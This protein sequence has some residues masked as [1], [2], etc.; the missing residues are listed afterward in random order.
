M[1]IKQA[2]CYWRVGS[3]PWSGDST[4]SNLWKDSDETMETS[5]AFFHQSKGYQYPLMRC[6][7]KVQDMYRK[8]EKTIAKISGADKNWI[9][10]WLIKGWRHHEGKQALVTYFWSS[11]KWTA[12]GCFT[13][14]KHGKKPGLQQLC[15]V[16]FYM[17]KDLLININRT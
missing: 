3:G 9:L 8:Q 10:P 15:E 1:K 7:L 14:L 17:E 4:K 5:R 6:S 11:S 13:W 12:T 2:P 16:S